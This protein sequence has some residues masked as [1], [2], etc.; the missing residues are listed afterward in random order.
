LVDNTNRFVVYGHTHLYE[1]VPL[2]TN[3]GGPQSE[4]LV[5]FN[6]GTWHSYY[7]LAIKNPKEEK[8]VPYQ[9]LT[10][11]TFFTPDEH[12][13]RRFETWSGAYA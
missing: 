1:I 4:S 7:D 10:Y 5:Y 12:D 3:D 9:A 2:G 13:G 11:V 6:S 8:F